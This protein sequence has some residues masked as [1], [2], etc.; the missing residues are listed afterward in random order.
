MCNNKYIFLCREYN[1][2]DCRIPLINFL[3]KEKGSHITVISIPTKTSSGLH[4]RHEYFSGSNLKIENLAHILF[5]S[6][7]A[8]VMSW[9]SE[10]IE[11]SNNKYVRYRLW[12]FIWK[13][14]F[15]RQYQNSIYQEKFLKLIKDNVII[16]D[17][18]F[19]DE[20]RTFVVRWLK[21][22]VQ[23]KVLCMAHG[24]NT[25]LNLWNDLP[26]MKNIKRVSQG[27]LTVYSPSSNHSSYLDQF[28]T[29]ISFIN[30]GNTRFDTDWVLHHTPMFNHKKL[31]I[32][33]NYKTKVL[34]V[35]SK[36]EYGQDAS[37][38]AKFIHT[39]CRLDN[40]ALCLKP[41]TRGMSIESL[42]ISLGNNISVEYGTP[43]S[44]LIHW[45]D[46]VVFTGSSIIFEAMIKHKKILYLSCLQNYQTIFDTLPED[47]I[48]RELN[49][50]GENIERLSE[51]DHAESLNEFLITHV[52]AGERDGK[53]CKNFFEN[54][55]VQKAKV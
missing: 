13:S 23:S 24:Q 25:Y 10:N 11:R 6:K 26:L 27:G 33:N 45:A 3:L 14:F 22:N 55:L 32:F 2:L 52:F 38:V 16:V 49:D 35:M 5:N 44:E 46:I 12:P 21:E 8:K 47:L 50:I 18:I 51:V 19:L 43:T 30:I 17:D 20:D 53:V 48:C 4:V 31:K 42:D 15:Y 39:I 40:L 36:L 1:D 7:L 9:L 41:H 54:Y 29:D 34:F 37:L 28:Y